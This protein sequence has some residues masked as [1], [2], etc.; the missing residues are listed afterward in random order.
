MLSV[1]NALVIAGGA[2]SSAIDEKWRGEEDPRVS[3]P[4]GKPEAINRRVVIIFT[5]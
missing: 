2:K 5:R 3:T 4:D 1:R